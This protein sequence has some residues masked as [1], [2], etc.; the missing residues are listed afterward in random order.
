MSG[1]GH[2]LESEARSAVGGGDDTAVGKVVAQEDTTH[3]EVGFVGVG[4]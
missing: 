4:P 2:L 1:L 3:G